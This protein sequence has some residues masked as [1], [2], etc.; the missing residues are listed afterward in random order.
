MTNE[1]KL[2][3]ELRKCKYS[4]PEIAKHAA[5]AI[6]ALV[7]IIDVVRKERDV[8]YKEL[9]RLKECDTCGHYHECGYDDIECIACENG[10]EYIFRG[11][12]DE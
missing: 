8:A 4:A 9:N 5:D 12:T 6:D 11:I 3:E 2:T 10:S 1:M 7:T